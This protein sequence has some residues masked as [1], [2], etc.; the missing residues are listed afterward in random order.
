MN[1][2]EGLLYSP[3]VGQ[4]YPIEV[5]IDHKDLPN[6]IGVELVVTPIE[7]GV[8]KPYIVQELQIVKNEG[9]KTYYKLDYSLK[10]SG[11]Y[12]Y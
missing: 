4:E 3:H 12:K 1:L 2:P 6:C 10:N 7:D 8:M 9:S 5:V 11:V